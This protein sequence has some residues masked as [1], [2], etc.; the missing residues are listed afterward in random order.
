[1]KFQKRFFYSLTG[2]AITKV[3]NLSSRDF[4]D[5]D[6]VPAIQ[7]MEWPSQAKEWLSRKRSSG[8]PTR[9]LLDECCTSKCYVVPAAC[10][11]SI[12]SEKR[13]EWRLSFTE[14]ELKLARSFSEKQR[15][16]YIVAKMI[17]KTA[18]NQLRNTV[19]SLKHARLVT[20]YDV[21]TTMFWLCESSTNWDD[22]I[23]NVEIIINKL[24]GYVGNGFLP[25]YFLPEKNLIKGLNQDMVTICEDML[26]E[27]SNLPVHIF[28]A[29]FHQ[30]YSSSFQYDTRFSAI[31]RKMYIEICDFETTGRPTRKLI[32]LSILH[33]MVEISRTVVHSD[34]ELDFS[35]NVMVNALNE[36]HDQFVMAFG[37]T[38]I[39]DEE[40]LCRLSSEKEMFEKVSLVHEIFLNTLANPT[41]ISQ[42]G[43]DA[44]AVLE[45][46]FSEN[47]PAASLA[48]KGIAEIIEF[49]E[50][51]RL[52]SKNA[53]L[54]KA[55]E[56]AY[57]S[58]ENL[59]KE[60]DE[61]EEKLQELHDIYSQT[62]ETALFAYHSIVKGNNLTETKDFA[63]HEEKVI[64]YSSGSFEEDLSGIF[65]EESIGCPSSRER[66]VLLLSKVQKNEIHI[67]IG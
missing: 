32:L 49:A 43:I 52:N 20:S 63:C 33:I 25:D 56:E 40:N 6:F 28:K 15:Q 48:Y 10:K 23:A 22:L 16:S 61:S 31:L 19:P 26:T 27:V 57:G 5:H 53:Y 21:K 12:R 58:V 62:A 46:F 30:T 9:E 1:M 18:V 34:E 2:P 55:A 65:E 47:V 59:F 4:F 3:E 17:V 67:P 29:C 54:V 37:A 36:L 44:F 66:L 60:A 24:L 45:A 51:V 64:V 11:E 42:L 8:W 35:I 41:V 39:F 14:T 38:T 50:L 7:C 13:K